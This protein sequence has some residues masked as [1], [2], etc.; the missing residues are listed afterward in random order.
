MPNRASLLRASALRSLRDPRH[1]SFSLAQFLLVGQPLS[2]LLDPPLTQSPRP[3][4]GLCHVYRQ[5]CP[6]LPNSPAAG[7]PFTSLE[8]L[9]VHVCVHDCACS[10]WVCSTGLLGVHMPVCACVCVSRDCWKVGGMGATSTGEP[11]GVRHSAETRW[12]PGIRTHLPKQQPCFCPQRQK[13]NSVVGRTLCFSGP[14]TRNHE[15][16]ALTEGKA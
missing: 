5:D 7:V 11:A 1:T 12:A 2:L 4:G 15:P 3:H 6:C 16:G 14:K 10:C 13:L 9:R 8:R